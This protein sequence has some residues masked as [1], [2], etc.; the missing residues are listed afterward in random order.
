M[1]N[2]SD[3]DLDAILVPTAPE[4]PP[5]NTQP[6]YSSGDLSTRSARSR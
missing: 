2:M 3:L 5:S 4:A 1:K 6:S